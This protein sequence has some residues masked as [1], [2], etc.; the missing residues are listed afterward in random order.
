M[1][2]DTF[3][4]GYADDLVLVITEKDVKI[5]KGKLNLAMHGIN[6]WME[7]HGLLAMAKTEIVLFTRK[8][9]ETIIPMRIGEDRIVT[10]DNLKITFLGDLGFTEWKLGV[11]RAKC[12]LRKHG[13]I[14]VIRR[15]EV[16]LDGVGDY[17][18]LVWPV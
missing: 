17:R 13:P 15:R 16:T 7:D 9:I 8:N 4:V 10:K 2:K 5:A 14:G 18:L 12:L 3:T 6:Y 11:T 1:P